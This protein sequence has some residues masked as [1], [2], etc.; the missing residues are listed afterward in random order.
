MAA[1]SDVNSKS[2]PRVASQ[3]ATSRPG[4]VGWLPLLSVV[5]AVGTLI[6]A[7]AYTGARAEAAWAQP[8]FWIALLV[9]ALPVASRLL[10]PT[11]SRR[12]RI[13]LL[14]VFGITLHLFK[15]LQYPL[16][17]QDT[18]ELRHWR[19][20][21]D[22]AAT[23][24]LFQA[25]PILPISPWYPGMEIVTNAISDLTGLSVFHAAVI[26]IGVARLLFI[27][28]LYLF[29]EQVGK[30]FGRLHNAEWVAGIAT[31]LYMTNPHFAFFDGTLSYESLALPLCAFVLFVVSS[32][33]GAPTEQRMGMTLAIWL[34]AA[35]LVI[36]HHLTS[37]A[38]VASL[39]LWAAI[40]A[41]R[42]RRIW[43][44]GGVDGPALLC[45]ALTFAWSVFTG[46]RGAA[47]LGESV[48]AA[49]QGLARVVHGVSPPHQLFSDY[50]GSV[51][52]VWERA[53]VLS[54]VALI[55]LL[56]LV[57]L[58]HV[59]RFHRSNAVALGLAL[60]ALAYPV[61]QVFRFTPLGGEV[62][63]RATEFVFVG[64]AFVLASG[65]TQRR[66]LG[67][68]TWRRTV[69]AISAIGIMLLGGVIGG[70]GPPWY[71]MPGPY[72]V[73]ADTRSI[74]PEGIAA[75][76]WAGSHLGRGQRVATDR[77]DSLLLATSGTAW[78]VT[79]AVEGIPVD[80]LFTSPQFGASEQAIVRDGRIH[81]LVVD[82]R[83]SSGLPRI[84]YYYSRGEPKAFQYTSPIDQ[85]ALIKFD[86]V[87]G[88]SRLF[89]SGNVV[90]YDV[91][92]FNGPP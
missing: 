6:T 89:D 50:A 29:F 1:R 88:V 45:L 8:L 15:A 22:I 24:H 23:N 34:G 80:R 69:L 53:V 28:A 30:S 55:V 42:E 44:P 77:V 54:S 43:H 86:A 81:Y 66:L 5:A 72:L 82:R 63:D 13:G 84:G 68:M 52:P 78:P 9:G 85:A 14:V 87:P 51:A 49:A 18:D 70:S 92:G 67:Q 47:Y 20:A 16:S 38:L 57:E 48:V 90:I 33:L 25:N 75:A 21:Q 3:A 41:W 74:T 59:W 91:G 65:A 40:S 46:G 35:A 27:L 83:L 39:M 19:T 12:E 71:R 2:R 31:L 26:L 58:P 60:V 32:R 76:E 11:A 10:S 56:L 37:Y 36:T 17:F 7:L 61:S 73:S 64:I 79:S 4:D 62:A